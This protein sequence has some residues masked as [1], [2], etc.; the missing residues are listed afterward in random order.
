MFFY[1]TASESDE[2]T[3]ID[4]LPSQCRLITD[5]HVEPSATQSTLKPKETT[6]DPHESIY[7]DEPNSSS[8]KVFPSLHPKAPVIWIAFGTIFVLLIVIIALMV[9]IFRQQRTRPRPRRSLYPSDF[10][11]GEDERFLNT[12]NSNRN[13]YD[14]PHE[15]LDMGRLVRNGSSFREHVHS[16]REVNSF[17]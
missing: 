8:T 5:V 1:V 13:N 14:P 12:N 4:N 10:S 15:A 17:L 11:P 2:L 6:K 3:S 9:F 7:A 16:L